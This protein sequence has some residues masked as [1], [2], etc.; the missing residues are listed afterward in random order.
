MDPCVHSRA[1]NCLF[2]AARRECHVAASA[3]S[4]QTRQSLSHPTGKNPKSDRPFDESVE[5]KLSDATS[6]RAPYHLINAALNVPASKNPAMQGRLT[7]FFLFS[8]AVCGSPLTGYKRTNEWENKDGHLDL[9]TAMAISGAAAAP[10]M[11]SAHEG[12]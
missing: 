10:Q 11:G 6:P 4:Q 7:D 12:G 3:L 8:H 5:L 1:G 2:L 9:G